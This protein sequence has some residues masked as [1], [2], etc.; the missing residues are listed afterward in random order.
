MVARKAAVVGLRN[1]RVIPRAREAG[2]Q[3][4]SFCFIRLILIAV[5]ICALPACATEEQARTAGPP[6]IGGDFIN[7]EEES[8]PLTIVRHGLEVRRWRIVPKERLTR[9]EVEG[10]GEIVVADEA[11]D[12]VSVPGPTTGERWR[13]ALAREDLRQASALR[14][15][16]LHAMD[17]AEPVI[18]LDDVTARALK[19]N[20]LRIV[21]IPLDRA[22]GL[23]RNLGPAPSTRTTWFG[24]AHAWQPL[25]EQPIRDGG[26]AIIVDGRVRR[27]MGGRLELMSRGW[28]VQLEDGPR[29]YVELAPEYGRRRDEGYAELL[30]A[31]GYRG[32]RFEAMSLGLFLEEGYAY[33]VT[34]ESPSIDWVEGEGSD[35]GANG[36][37]GAAGV[38]DAGGAG[39]Y[40]GGA[41]PATLAPSTVGERLF[42]RERGEI[43]REFLVL[44][45][46]IPERFHVQSQDE[47]QP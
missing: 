25:I 14:R 24:Q 18:P 10:G 8:G 31:R 45:A 2:I 27:F 42:I 21:R 34:G 15:S 30:G 26:E 41:G 33:I 6:Q 39:G 44:I 19:R 13:E 16:V 3:S 5:I 22:E 17:L 38:E 4:S 35:D 20:G 7:N 11:G 28:T 29:V 23:L 47:T 1:K 9:V 43:S 37:A 12:T 40:M 32:E 46:R 36:G